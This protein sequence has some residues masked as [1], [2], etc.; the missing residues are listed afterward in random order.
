MTEKKIIES[1]NTAVEEITPNILDDLMAELNIS[2]EPKEL[3][4]DAIAKDEAASTS[5]S[6]EWVKRDG[7]VP[8]R[9]VMSVAASL[10]LVVAGISLSVTG[11]PPLALVSLD[12]NPGIEISINNKERVIEAIPINDEATEI[13]A[14]M[15]LKGTDIDVA[16]NAIVGSML[17][18]G[19]LTD[20]SNS[21]LLS[22]SSDDEQVGTAIEKRLS[23]QINKYLENTEI[24][25]AVLGQY[26][27]NDEATRTFADANGISLGKAWLIKNLL[28]TGSTKMKE[29][30]LLGLKT[31]EL[32]LLGQKRGVTKTTSYGNAESS[33]YIGEEK[34][35]AAALKQ[36]GVSKSDA[37]NI[38]YEFDVERGTLIYEVSFRAGD[39]EYDYD[40]NAYNGSVVS[41]E[42]EYEP[43]YTAPKSSGG[44]SSG[45]TSSGSASSGNASSG[46]SSGTVRSGDDEYK[47]ENGVVYEKDDGRWEPEY[48]KKVENGTVYEKDDGRWEAEDNDYD[49]DYDDDDD[50]DDD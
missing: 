41:F 47:V 45:N 14:D 35:L 1:L 39:Y 23:Q 16:C 27:V 22:V 37:T 30:D 2:A 46:N 43:R 49:D 4:Q 19:Y 32:I 20:L 40:I 15:D 11:R 36:A 12:V 24:A 42:K 50:D 7:L 8:W 29:S 44:G 18:H 48:D 13:L 10:L 5:A 31:Q 26:G 6:R 9:R 28:K 34:A 17:T 21:I 33:Q 25:A 38:R 3:M